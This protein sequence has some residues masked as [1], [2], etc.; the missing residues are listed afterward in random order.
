MRKPLLYAPHESILLA[1]HDEPWA[2]TLLEK[3]PARH[4]LD[5]QPLQ[6]VL[7][8]DKRF[9]DFSESG[10]LAFPDDSMTEQ[11]DVIA[12]LRNDARAHL[13]Y[14]D[15]DTP[16]RRLL[17]TFPFVRYS[18]RYIREADHPKLVNVVTRELRCLLPDVVRETLDLHR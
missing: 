2:R 5:F 1:L 3:L 6:R 18:A 7:D 17:H 9:D 10:W 16:S 8:D 11:L 14:D 12:T 4:T 15:L 13:K